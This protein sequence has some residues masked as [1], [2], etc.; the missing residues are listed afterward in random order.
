MKH[1]DFKDHMHEH[2]G[3]MH[4]SHHGHHAGGMY[5]NEVD[6]PHVPSHGHQEAGLGCADFKGEAQS[7]AY[8]QAGPQGCKSDERK[9][10]AQFKNYHWDSDTGGASGH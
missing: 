10:S 3:M 1:Q 6:K 9:Y 8:G 5:K 7:I 4:R 2:K